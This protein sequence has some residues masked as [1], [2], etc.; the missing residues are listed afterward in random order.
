MRRGYEVILSSDNAL[1]EKIAIEQQHTAV[2]KAIRGRNPE[3]ARSAVHAHL[4]STED[5]RRP[6]PN[7]RRRRAKYSQQSG[8]I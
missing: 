4:R 2:F 7:R 8:R 3:A 1:E 6:D 5:V